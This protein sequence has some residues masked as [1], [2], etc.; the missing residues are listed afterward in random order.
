MLAEPAPRDAGE[1]FRV[2]RAQEVEAVLATI[3]DAVPVNYRALMKKVEHLVATL[4][5]SDDEGS[6]NGAD[7]RDH[8]RQ[9]P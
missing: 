9:L 7:D 3:T 8:H 5:Q 2:A 6:T 1:L 4:D